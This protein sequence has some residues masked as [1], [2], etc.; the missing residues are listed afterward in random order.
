MDNVKGIARFPATN[1]A[2]LETDMDVPVFGLEFGNLS[3]FTQS[4]QRLRG[5]LVVIAPAIVQNRGEAVGGY[6][7]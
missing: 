7:I 2:K 1:L 5:W 4:I 3:L 6:P